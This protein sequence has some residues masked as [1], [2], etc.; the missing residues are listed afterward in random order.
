MKNR[1]DDKE[2]ELMVVSAAVEQADAPQTKRRKLV[3]VADKDGASSSSATSS[4]PF[5]KYA[6]KI[7][8]AEEAIAAGV[9]EVFKHKAPKTKVPFYNGNKTFA[10]SASCGF[11][12]RL[13][14]ENWK[15]FMS[16]VKETTAPAVPVV[17]CSAALE[18]VETGLDHPKSEEVQGAMML[19]QD[20]RP[21]V[22]VATS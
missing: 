15:S 12:K 6:A 7:A 5:A 1:R 14:K 17:E 9:A 19:V 11:I 2:V 16:F 18:V 13:E 22:V 10:V 21:D 3:Q 8:V 4:A 20:L